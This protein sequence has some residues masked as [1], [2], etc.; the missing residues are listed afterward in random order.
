ME[1][2]TLYNKIETYGKMI[3]FS[4]SIF[5]LPFA[6]SAIV[7]ASYN[8]PV[9]LTKILWIVVAMVSARSAAMGFNRLVDRNQDSGN[10]RTSTRE[11]PDGKIDLKSAK[12]FIFI[13]SLI[14]FLSAYMLFGT[15]SLLLSFVVLFLLCFYSYTKRFTYFSHLYLGFVISLAPICV[16]FVITGCISLGISL[17]SLSLMMYIAGFDILYSC[18]DFE[19]DKNEG[20][21]S[22]PVKFGIKKSMQIAM[23]LHIISFTAF[24]SLICFFD[25]GVIYIITIIIIG[26]LFIIEHLIVTPENFKNINIAFFHINSVIS[27][28]LFVG[29]CLDR[30]F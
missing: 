24:L 17:L 18:Q 25:M 23:F 22:I 14:F 12:A 6:L 21:F 1:S 28:I 4:H 10:P 9:S 11:I 30:F 3:K 29:V 20:L 26:I 27:V 13:S 7:L 16:W 15:L 8:Y 2:K 19:F 5:A